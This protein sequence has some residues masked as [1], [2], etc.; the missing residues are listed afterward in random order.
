MIDL[1]AKPVLEVLGGTSLLP[2]SQSSGS[3]E[4]LGARDR[5]TSA[6]EGK[7]SLVQPW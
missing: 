4:G 3:R 1:A 2:V 5:Q 7:P 6:A